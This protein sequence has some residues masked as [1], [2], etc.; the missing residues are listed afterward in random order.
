[1]RFFAGPERSI[2][3]AIRVVAAKIRASD[4]TITAGAIRIITVNE[5]FIAIR[6]IAVAIWTITANVF[7]CADKQQ[8]YC[9]ATVDSAPSKRKKEKSMII[10]SSPNRSALKALH[11]NK[12]IEEIKKQ[13]PTRNCKKSQT[14]EG[15]RESTA[16][17]V[18]LLLRCSIQPVY[19]L[20]PRMCRWPVPM[21]RLRFSLNFE[22]WF[23]VTSQSNQS[24]L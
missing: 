16:G 7:S 1:M 13:N 8:L 18:V 5:H 22:L 17:H 11:A 19:G 23:L 9:V 12:D 3:G 24:E 21:R 20:E 10:T 15:G 14:Q 2:A 4:A 6:A